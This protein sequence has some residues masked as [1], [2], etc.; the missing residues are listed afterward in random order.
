MMPQEP[1]APIDFAPMPGWS[2]AKCRD[3]GF[4]LEFWP[5]NWQMMRS[6]QSDQYCWVGEWHVGPFVFGLSCNVGWKN[7]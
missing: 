5:F 1:S 2:W 3:I 6:R 4:R 7:V